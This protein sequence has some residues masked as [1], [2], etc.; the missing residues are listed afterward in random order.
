MDGIVV[1]ELI[2]VTVSPARQTYSQWTVVFRQLIKRSF[3]QQDYFI[4]V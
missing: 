2:A 1:L 3:A 4:I